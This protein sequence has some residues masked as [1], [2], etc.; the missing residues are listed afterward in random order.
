MDDPGSKTT[1]PSARWRVRPHEQRGILLAGDVIA[2]LL[3]L[4]IS[5]YIWGQRDLWF[6]FSLSFLEERVT[7]WFYFLP[8]AWLVLLVGLYDIHRAHN[9]RKTVNGIAI[10]ALIGFIIYAIIYV[11][12]QGTLNRIG[13]A[14]FLITASIL[15]LL[16]RLAYI[17]IF[18]TSAL[19]RR[20]LVVGAGRAGRR[21][22]EAY[23][24]LW[25]PPFFFVGFVD[26][27]PQKLGRQEEGF[28]VLS[29]S[30]SL[31][32][33][34][35]RESVSDIVV[36]ITGEMKGDTFQT[37]LDAQ[38]RG[39][40]V[41]PMPTLYEEMMGRVP[42][43][44]LESDWLLRSFVDQARA[45]GFYEAGKRLLD[46][47]GSMIGISIFA[48]IYPLASI[49]ILLESGPP[50]IYKQIRSGKG[51]KPYQ[52]YKF[53]TMCQDAEKDGVRLTLEKDSRITKVGTFLR[54]THIDELPQFFNVLRGEMSLVGPRSERPE[55]ISE[56]QK[57]IPFYR[58]RLLVKPGITGLAQVN[59][60]YYN[61]VEE[62]AV[63]LEYDLYYIKHRNL[64]MDLVI[65]LRTVGQV[66][67]MRGR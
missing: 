9:W 21:L 53:R 17:R 43:H 49:L 35:S 34:V 31:L 23:K 45:G 19:N 32:E 26:D 42:V 60:S 63:K 33:L 51:G 36:A 46:I 4:F 25:P 15:T 18:T 57:Q 11:L 39:I 22:A 8:L 5:L 50:V 62:M 29:N 10:A 47:F 3:A 66:F 20:V 56:F 64:L 27:D 52:T 61:T 37:I 30:G 67:G 2:A 40:E 6:N 48:L 14:A 16:W 54:K 28:P 58:A 13:I 7:L 44:H 59:Y 24:N 55:W 1:P 41:T 12:V 38:E 65:L